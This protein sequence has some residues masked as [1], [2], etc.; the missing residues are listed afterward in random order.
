M[1]GAICGFTLA[2]VGVGFWGCQHKDKEPSADDNSQTTTS[3]K[4]APGAPK[5]SKKDL[6]AVLAKVD[7]A[8]ITVGN[9]QYRI[10][11][12][13]PYVRDRYTSLETKRDFLQKLIQFEVLA[14]EAKRRGFDKDPTVVRTLKRAMIQKLTK[15]E[16]ENKL[17]PSYITDAE[18]KEFYEK[19]K[20]MYT[21]EER[22][23]VSAIILRGFG[24]AKQVAKQAM[25]PVG[26]T[27]K[28]F[29]DLVAKYSIDAGTKLR[30]GDLRYFTRNDKKLPRTVVEAT[31]KLSKTGEVAGPINGGNGKYYI[32]RQTGRHRAIHKTLDQVK[33]QIRNRL[34]RQKRR[35]AQ[36]N[37]LKQL[38]AK[39][40]IVTFE[41]N[42]N[43]VRI[44]RQR[45]R[46]GRRHGFT[47]HA[48]PMPPPLTNGNK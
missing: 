20:P 2:M 24:H 12:M 37:F 3:K 4:V 44:D 26:R 6:Q 34:Y 13:S 48:Q 18:L 36:K 33:R 7:D 25:G 40:K 43:K 47:G 39:A 27:N 16:F 35:E 28:G 17:K 15:D 45:R 14:K 9:F 8:V 32:I 31:F 5:Q 23:R 29:R 11:R 19:N 46:R 21:K 22:V 41:Q 42:L 10:N 1:L 38:K 30:G